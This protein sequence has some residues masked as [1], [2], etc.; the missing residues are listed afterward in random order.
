MDTV[1]LVQ[2]LRPNGRRREVEASIGNETAEKARGMILSCEVLM[3]GQVVLYAKYP[4]DKEEEEFCRL[5]SN[6]PEIQMI[7]EKM[8]QDKWNEKKTREV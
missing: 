5:S 7:L 2:Y 4:E 1:K 8:I 6:G 3:T